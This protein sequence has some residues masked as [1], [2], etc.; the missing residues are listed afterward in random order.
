MGLA[1]LPRLAGLMPLQGASPAD[2][3]GQLVAAATVGAI[4]NDSAQV[5][6]LNRT[7]MPSLSVS[8]TPNLLLYSMLRDQVN[9]PTT[10]GQHQ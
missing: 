3:R 8:S 9:A 5:G 4:R 6:S 10:P 7:A 1:G 2:V